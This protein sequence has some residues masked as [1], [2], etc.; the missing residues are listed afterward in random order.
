MWGCREHWFKLPKTL[1]D[2][3]WQEYRPGQE[4]DKKPSARYIAVAALVRG[5]IEGKVTLNPDGSLIV[6]EDYPIF[7]AGKAQT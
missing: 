3:I 2:S 5:W 4:I 1:R 7:P 6:H